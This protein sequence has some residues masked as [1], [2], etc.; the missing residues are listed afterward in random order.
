MG[1]FCSGLIDFDFDD[2]IWLK[3]DVLC[4]IDVDVLE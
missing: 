3:N 1:V 2:G 4:L